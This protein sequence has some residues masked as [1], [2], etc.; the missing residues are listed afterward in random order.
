MQQRTG[1]E[2]GRVKKRT[3]NPG[4]AIVYYIFDVLYVDGYSL[5]R[6]DLEQRK[7]VL[8]QLLTPNA[9]FRYSEAFP[10]QGLQLFEAAKLQGLEGIV[11]K[12]RTSCYE[13]KRSRDWLKVKTTMRQECVIGG[14]TEP[15][16]SRENF[17][18]LVLGLYDDQG[19]LVPVG[20][21]GSG[22]TQKTHA[23][24]WERLRKLETDKSPFSRK[25]EASRGVHY[26]RPELVAEIKFTEWTH[27]GQKGG[28]KM[29]A[30]VFQGLRSDK[31]PKECRFE[32]P[33]KASVEKR[34]PKK[35]K[36][37]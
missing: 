30:P 32:I 29:R 8:Q 23:A 2:P 21:A 19:K 26:V 14:Y 20:Q 37:A 9:T 11:A 34:T 27:E 31:K 24:M 16:G 36:A 4:I 35:G 17:G 18:S 7:Q 13:T 15:R 1:F 28:L 12:R 3:R 6:V 33:H 5:L 10:E 22:F 25:P